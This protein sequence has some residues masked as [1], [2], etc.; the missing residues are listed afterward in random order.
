MAQEKRPAE[1]CAMLLADVRPQR[2]C[3]AFLI[4]L[5]LLG[6]ACILQDSPHTPAYAYRII[7]TSFLSERACAGSY[8]QFSYGNSNLS[9]LTGSTLAR[10]V[11]S[12]PCEPGPRS[13]TRRRACRALWAPAAP[14][15]R[16]SPGGRVRIRT[17]RWSSRA[18]AVRAEAPGQRSGVPCGG[19]SGPA[20]RWKDGLSGGKRVF[21]VL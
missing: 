18:G 5:A 21:K 15:P 9:I 19:G 1:S 3:R 20:H 10:T 7:V 17:G 4:G 16:W 12:G 2:L 11:R 8:Y 14:A 6:V 13:C